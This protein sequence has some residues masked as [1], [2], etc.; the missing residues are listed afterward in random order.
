MKI[1]IY[2]IKIKEIPLDSK[3]KS[4]D[5][6]YLAIKQLQFNWRAIWR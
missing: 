5:T 6:G 3:I 4:P 1:S 2:F